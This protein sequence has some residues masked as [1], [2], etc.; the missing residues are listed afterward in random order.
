MQIQTPDWVKHA[1]FY[2][3]FPDRFA[4]SQ[5]L[6]KRLLKSPTWEDWHTAPTLQGYKGGDLWGVLEQLDYL[7]DLGIT[8][9]YFTPIFQSASNHRYHTHDYYLVDP[10]LGGNEAFR[11]LLDEAHRRGIKVVLDGVFNHASRGFFFFHDILENGP[12]SPWLDWFRIEGWPLAAYDGD[13]PANYVGW[14]GNRALP[15]FNHD[16]PEVREY[17]M[18]IAE[19]WIQFGIDGWRLDVPFEVKTPGFWQEFRDRVKAINPDAYI[20]GEVWGDSRE[21]LDGT[22]FDGVMNYLFAA[23]TIAF[24]A[25]DRVVMDQV[26]DRSYEPYPPLFATE[27]AEKI[28]H[29]LQLYP[30]DI[31]LTQLNLLASHDTARLLTIAAG[32]RASVELSTLLL[33]TFPGAPSIYYGDEVGLPGALD[34]DSRRGFPLEADWDQE[35]FIYHRQLIELRYTYPALRIGDYQ[36]LFAEGTVYIFARTLE[37]EE[38]IVA[39]NIG[40]APIKTSVL[41]SDAGLQ[42]QPQKQLFGSSQFEWTSEGQLI[43]DLPARSGCILG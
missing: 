4:A 6:R 32:D 37:T 11:E 3:I 10:I 13:R 24:T 2:Q 30:W 22:Q 16:N 20:V 8:A 31:Q 39:V 9:I 43:I 15:V 29:L 38:L 5:Q 35:I 1:V 7:Q 40:T 42:T 19:Y 18:E 41:P 36:V 27:Y 33:L 34:P 28:Q 14:A 25:G 12:Y 17:I 23:P 26:Q 21:W